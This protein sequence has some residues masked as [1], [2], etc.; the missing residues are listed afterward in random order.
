LRKE[1]TVLS[2]FLTASSGESNMIGKNSAKTIPAI[3]DSASWGKHS[4]YGEES[5]RK[6][7]PD[8]RASRA[9]LRAASGVHDSFSG[10]LET[11]SFTQRENDPPSGASPLRKP[12]W[13]CVFTAPG[14][15]AWRGK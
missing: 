10:S 5:H 11:S 8:S 14:I 6:V 15:I 2:R 13:A 12:R 7:V 4:P 3:P 1:S 9:E